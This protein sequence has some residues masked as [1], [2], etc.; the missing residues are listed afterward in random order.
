MTFSHLKLKINMDIDNLIFTFFSLS[1]PFYKNSFMNTTM[2]VKLLHAFY[3]LDYFFSS[4]KILSNRPN[5]PNKKGILKNKK[6]KKS[7]SSS[8]EPL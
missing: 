1:N 8:I 6:P 7:K 3:F 2:R 5:G 4:Y